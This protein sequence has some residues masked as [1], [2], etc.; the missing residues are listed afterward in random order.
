MKQKNIFMAEKYEIVEQIAVKQITKYAED[1]EKFI[2]SV[3]GV[4]QTKIIYTE[5]AS[6]CCSFLSNLPGLVKRKN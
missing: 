3:R 6:I 5:H 1:D 2:F 4:A